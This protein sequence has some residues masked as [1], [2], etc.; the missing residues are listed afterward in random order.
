MKCWILRYYFKDFW[1]VGGYT[2]TVRIYWKYTDIQWEA[3]K[4]VNPVFTNNAKINFH[5]RESKFVHFYI[6]LIIKISSNQCWKDSSSN[7]W[8]SIVIINLYTFFHKNVN[9]IIKIVFEKSVSSFMRFEWA[10]SVHEILT[11]W[12]NCANRRCK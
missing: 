1:N 10:I 12:L 2:E 8:Y 3:L 5:K 6:N 11:I 9:R 4:P 7:A